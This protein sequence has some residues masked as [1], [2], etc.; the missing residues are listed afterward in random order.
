MPGVQQQPRRSAQS[1]ELSNETKRVLGH[2]LH[3]QGYSLDRAFPDDSVEHESGGC[4]TSLGAEALS[5]TA[6]SF[7]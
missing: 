1:E 3:V 6:H 4:S 7:S 5:L 2:V